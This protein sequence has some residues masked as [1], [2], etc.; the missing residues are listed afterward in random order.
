MRAGLGIAVVPREVALPFA[1]GN[2]LRVIPLTDPWAKR[3]FAICFRD[4]A[5]L[6]PAARLLV[7]HLSS[8][9]SSG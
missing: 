5:H 6:S 9:Q 8:R 2:A 4:E 7:K 1:Q 3:R